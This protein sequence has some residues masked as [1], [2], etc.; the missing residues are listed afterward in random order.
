M[1]SRAVVAGVDG[2][3]QRLGARRL[4]PQRE[5]GPQRR[6]ALDLAGD[7]AR[8]DG[9]E[10]QVALGQPQ[11]GLVAGGAQP[12]VERVAHRPRQLAAQDVPAVG[13][14]EREPG[15]DPHAERLDGTPC[16][17]EDLLCVGVPGDVGDLHAQLLAHGLQGMVEAG[18]VG[19]G[20]QPAEQRVH[21][22]GV[23]RP[24][25]VRSSGVIAATPALIVTPRSRVKE[26]TRSPSSWPSRSLTASSAAR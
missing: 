26:R 10:L 6:V 16:P 4:R 7:D 24:C 12:S 9:E 5:L 22:G 18:R 17:D 1:R 2:R 19:H 13:V 23:Q 3:E 20:P 8:Q 11:D 15:A 25:A 21:R 14:L